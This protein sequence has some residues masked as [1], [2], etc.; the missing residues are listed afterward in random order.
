MFKISHR[1]IRA[2][3]ILEINW[4]CENCDA[5][6]LIIQTGAKKSVLPIEP[7]GTKK[8]K[9]SAAGEKTI[10]SL[11]TVKNGK[12]NVSSKRVWV[13]D[14]KQQYDEF[15]YVDNTF[16]S[17]TKEFFRQQKL[18]W[19]MFSPEK[20]RLY[21]TLLVLALYLLLQPYYP[22]FSL[23]FLYG[24]IVYLIYKVYKM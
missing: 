4:E 17:R 13:R 23:L 8:I 24:L 21:I 9:L 7:S 22:S 1:I 18:R 12:E 19:D 6:E 14:A 10:I 11:R 16:W 2:G 20:Q 15:E 3:E 5:Q